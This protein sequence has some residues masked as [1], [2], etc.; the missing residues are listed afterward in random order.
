ML[1]K[2]LAKLVLT[3]AMVAAA[4]S[5]TVAKEPNACATPDKRCTAA[6]T[7]DKDGWCKVYGCVGDKSFLLPFSCD[8]KAGGCLQKHC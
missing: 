6:T 4:V 2:S 1:A 7:C 5:P 3:A 8:E